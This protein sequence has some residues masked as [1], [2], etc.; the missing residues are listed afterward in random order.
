MAKKRGRPSGSITGEAKGELMQIRVSAAEKET[1]AAAA[2]LDGKDLSE[3]VRDRLRRLSR[4]ELEH[5]G[6]AV[7]FLSPSE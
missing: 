3:W 4:Q 7:A 1:F 2:A 5:A 6:R